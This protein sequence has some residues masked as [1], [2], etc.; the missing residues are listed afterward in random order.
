MPDP[1]GSCALLE[2]SARVE[3]NPIHITVLGCFIFAWKRD[4]RS[5]SASPNTGS[6]SVTVTPDPARAIPRGNTFSS[7]S[8]GAA[9]QGYEFAVLT[10]L[11]QTLNKF[12]LMDFAPSSRGGSPSASPNTGSANVTVTRDPARA[13]PR[14]KQN[15]LKLSS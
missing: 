15:K 11:A 9:S 4:G 7:K 13:I 2:D 14:G 5:P 10:S 12:K 6:A 1:A 8:C 3:T